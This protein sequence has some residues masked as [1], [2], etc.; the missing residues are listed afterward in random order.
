MQAEER[1]DL[2]PEK[3][4]DPDFD[5]DGVSR[6]LTIGDVTAA[7][8]FQAAL[9]IPGQLLPHDSKEHKVVQRGEELFAQI[10]CAFC[11]LP[12]MTLD[13]RFFSEPNPLNPPGTFS[14]TNQTFSFDMT[15]EGEKP[16][17]EKGAKGG[18]IVRAYTDLK[19]H[20]LCDDAHD[21]EAIRFFC[22]EYLAQNRPEQDDKPGTGFFI[23]RKLWDVGNSAPYGHRG[24]LTTITEAILVHGG[25]ARASREAFVGL[26]IAEQE[27]IVQFLKTLQVLPPESHLVSKEDHADD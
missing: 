12:A 27:A 14:D 7:V 8:I 13:S 10:G 3:E 5:A 20:N 6:E 23:T 19:R 15:K 4:W 25:E 16:R 18:A 2:N 22:N 21:P 1:F 9:S 24:D 11:H 17:L 26:S